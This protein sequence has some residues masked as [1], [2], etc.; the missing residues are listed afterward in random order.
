MGLYPI[1]SDRYPEMTPL[2]APAKLKEEITAPMEKSEKPSLA[3]RTGKK[4]LNV[5]PTK[6][7]RTLMIQI[8]VMGFQT[9]PRTSFMEPTNP[10]LVRASLSGH[11][12]TLNA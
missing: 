3:Q 2:M 12:T 7:R 5:W 4:V 1:R 9:F 10:R 11:G 6:A 8:N